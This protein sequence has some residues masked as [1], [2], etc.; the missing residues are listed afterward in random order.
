MTVCLRE[1]ALRRIYHQ[2]AAA[3]KSY[4]WNQQVWEKSGYKADGRNI[5]KLPLSS[6]KAPLVLIISCRAISG[7]P[8]ID[9]CVMCLERSQLVATHVLIAGLHSSL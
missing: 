8:E 1:Y 2:E 6:R 7:C 3:S 5:H 4:N 9:Q